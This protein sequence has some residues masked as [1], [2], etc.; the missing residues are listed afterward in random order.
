VS[1]FESWIHATIGTASAPAPAPAGND[2]LLDKAGLS[3]AQAGWTRFTVTVPQGTAS[4]TVVTQGGSGDADLYVRYGAEP[5]A[6]YFDCRPYTDGNAETCS[7]A[8]PPAGT[9][10]VGV[11]GYAAF[12]GLSI[13]ATLP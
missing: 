7:F 6:R 10:Y 8:N 9:W 4:F 1:S 2:V 11:R 5:S 13:R 12:S 3:G